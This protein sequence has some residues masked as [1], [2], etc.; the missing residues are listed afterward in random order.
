M[1][2][3]PRVPPRSV[4]F[5]SAFKLSTQPH[6]LSAGYAFK[7]DLDNN[8][9][10]GYV[11]PEPLRAAALA[12]LPLA[13]RAA[14][15]DGR[16]TVVYL[17][18][19][20]S[21]PPAPAL[22]DA[23]CE[24]GPSLLF[25][26]RVRR[27]RWFNDASGECVILRRQT[28]E[29]SVEG[30]RSSI[31]WPSGVESWEVSVERLSTSSTTRG[32]GGSEGGSE[33]T[34]SVS[35]L[36]CAA[37]VPVPPF[38]RFECNGASTT[39]IVI[40]LPLRE[41]S[42][43]ADASA[44]ALSA[45][46]VFC[47]LP[48]RKVGL[49]FAVHAEWSL[50]SSRDDIHHD[51]AWNLFLRDAMPALFAA[52]VAAQPPDASSPALDYLPP[53]L[54][55]SEPFWQPLIDGACRELRSSG[56]PVM[57]AETGELC[58]LNQL[59]RRP[60]CVSRRLL[61]SATL[62]EHTGMSFAAPSKL[63]GGGSTAAVLAA[64]GTTIRHGASSG[65]DAGEGDG[66]EDSTLAQLG[67]QELGLSEMAVCVRA[68]TTPPLLQPP[69]AAWL[70]ELYGALHSLC[71][72]ATG[73]MEAAS[74]LLRSL[75]M[76][77]VR[78]PL[79]GPSS[80]LGTLVSCDSGECFTRI[81]AEHAARGDAWRE[82]ALPNMRLL[83][84]RLEA[85][86]A[87]AESR[88]PTRLL[89]ALGIREAA[90]ADLVTHVL[91]EHAVAFAC[92]E[93]EGLEQGASRGIKRASASSSMRGHAR[94][95]AQLRLLRELAH[96]LPTEGELLVLVPAMPPFPSSQTEEE[97]SKMEEE[98]SMGTFYVAAACD[99]VLTHAL[100][101]L[102]GM[103]STTEHWRFRYQRSGDPGRD[104]CGGDGDEL[105]SQQVI[106]EVIEELRDEHFFRTRL[107]ATVAHNPTRFGCADERYHAAF[108]AAWLAALSGVELR[109]FVLE[110]LH[111]HARW[112]KEEF[113]YRHH[114]LKS[115]CR[116]DRAGLTHPHASQ[117]EMSV[118][119]QGAFWE[120][121]F[122]Q[123]G[124]ALGYLPCINPPL[125]AGH[126]ARMA[127]LGALGEL[128]VEV[129]VNVHSCLAALR[130]QSCLD[131]STRS[132]EMQ[133]PLLSW[134]GM[135]L[136]LGTSGGAINAQTRE[137]EQG[138][139]AQAFT[140]I[141][142]FVPATDGDPNAKPR[143]VHLANACWFEHGDAA[144]EL[145]DLLGLPN[146]ATCYAGARPLLVEALK[147]RR[148]FTLRELCTG[149]DSVSDALMDGALPFDEPTRAFAMS[150]L[151]GTWMN[152][153]QVAGV[154]S[155]V[156][157]IH[158]ICTYVYE[159]MAAMVASSQ[160]SPHFQTLHIHDLDGE[161]FD[162]RRIFIPAAHEPNEG[163][164]ISPHQVE[165]AGPRFST[166]E[167]VF[168]FSQSSDEEELAAACGLHA[169][170]SHYPASLRRFFTET[171]HVPARPRPSTSRLLEAMHN[172]ADAPFTEC[173]VRVVDSCQKLLAE[174][175]LHGLEEDT[176]RVVEASQ[177]CPRH[178]PGCSHPAC[179]ALGELFGRDRSI[180]AEGGGGS[181][182]GGGG[183]Y[184]IGIG[185]DAAEALAHKRRAMER[186]LA[187][188]KRYQLPELRGGLGDPFGSRNGG[189]GGAE[190]CVACPSCDDPGDFNLH[191]GFRTSSG[192]PVYVDRSVSLSDPQYGSLGPVAESFASVLLFLASTIGPSVP[193]AVHIFFEPPRTPTGLKRRE[194]L[195]FNKGGSLW[196]SLRAFV[197]LHASLPSVW[198][199]ECTI[200]WIV[201]MSH[202]LA[203]N[204]VEEHDARHEDLTEGMLKIVLPALVR[205]HQASQQHS[206][207]QHR[208]HSQHSQ[209]QQRGSGQYGGSHHGSR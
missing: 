185:T 86:L 174:A 141:E 112:I 113:Q 167:D 126:D 42:P 77:P 67:V 83:H 145:C 169:L 146:L 144:A 50:T 52:A 76:L 62:K 123:F 132:A 91:G 88:A 190:Q 57:R 94:L 15:S 81:P 166:S 17:P 209:R 5:K 192:L 9:L 153:V 48:M 20:P 199:P 127:A 97:R 121:A 135:R 109:A 181:S 157:R 24:R 12:A 197:S 182:G 66:G 59:L 74:R 55:V 119:V 98:A 200:F 110:E 100:G 107:G 122:A 168:W 143:P 137:A 172:L 154:D 6:V 136:L 115:T 53:G 195:G 1:S 104:F 71:M 111:T 13:A 10:L 163:E 102:V 204:L 49:R 46:D 16:S 23:L 106:D 205:Q 51:K 22:R 40:A 85:A 26:R 194:V 108:L 96:H 152:G 188:G 191:F 173:T 27:L 131:P 33:S 155:S 138:T 130:A 103:E 75:P 18:L 43:N 3:A 95:Y 179:R 89:E 160:D 170:C 161:F 105:G 176:P 60:S 19:R 7:F 25:L 134:L 178:G 180:G 65:R 124:L 128:G 21:A 14:W 207:Q 30:L 147:V 193:P 69:D 93:A 70:I 184:A 114:E 159:Q 44:D 164:L 37:K 208:Q 133:L 150:A 58:A 139:V 198:L 61:S 156:E 32:E 158:A 8:G 101:G 203:H 177:G 2:D 38:L 187:G 11:L 140:Q 28:V 202:E 148:Q 186:A 99:V 117:P 183:G 73:G 149:L 4:G 80:S 171:L 196:F 87:T 206:Q 125:P 201:T 35:Y 29:A 116:L 36:R 41:A 151:I 142:L 56:L 79:Q 175:D 92:G 31:A 189:G 63:G 72:Q 78:R 64:T 165:G 45:A 90:A 120:P 84:P 34:S 118:P 129:E 47:F 162:M 39:E 82:L 54:R 68:L